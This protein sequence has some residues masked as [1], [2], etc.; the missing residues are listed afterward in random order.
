[1]NSN[2]KTKTPIETSNNSNLEEENGESN[3]SQKKSSDSEQP[4][5]VYS[6]HTPEGPSPFTPHTP[7]EPPPPREAPP[8]IFQT[9]A[10]IDPPANVKDKKTPQ[11]RFND[12]VKLYYS[13]N[14][15]QYSNVNSELEV[16]FGTKGIKSLTRNDYDNVIKKLKSSGFKV[17]GNSIGEYYLRVQCEFLDSASGR[18]KLSDVRTEIKGLHN[19]QK[20]CKSSDDL[21]ALYAS[22]PTAIDFI[23]KKSNQGN[24]RYVLK[25]KF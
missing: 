10:D 12:L 19:I 4:K 2:E 21:K 9:E 1:M 24:F 18:F 6:P 25:N 3:Q 15:F 8:E 13:T 22:N 17:V 11:D 16:K 20:Y 5:R 7:D 23:H 14:P